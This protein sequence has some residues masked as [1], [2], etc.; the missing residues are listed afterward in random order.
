MVDKKLGTAVFPVNS[1]CREEKHSGRLRIQ[2]KTGFLHLAVKITRGAWRL[3]IGMFYT[4]TSLEVLVIFFSTTYVNFSVY[5]AGFET[6]Q[7]VLQPT[8]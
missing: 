2:Q 6:Q 7:K 3:D 5:Y 4:H 1:T 8:Q